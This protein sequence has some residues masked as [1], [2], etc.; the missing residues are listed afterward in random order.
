MLKRKN[1]KPGMLLLNKVS[2]NEGVVLGRKK[3]K[4]LL[5]ARPGFVQVRYLPGLSTQY[6]YRTWSLAHCQRVG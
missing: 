2:Y 3:G 4:K 6:R 5:K 1:L